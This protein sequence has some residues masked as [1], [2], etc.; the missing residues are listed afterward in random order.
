MGREMIFEVRKDGKPIWPDPNNIDDALFVC[1]RDDSTSYLANYVMNSMPE[2]S[3]DDTE[4]VVLLEQKDE[5]YF[6]IRER[7][8]EFYEKDLAEIQKA[9]DTLDD[10]REARRH[11]NYVDFF[12]FSESMEA[13]QE[14]IDDNNWSRAGHLI[15][16]LDKCMDRMNYLIESDVVDGCINQIENKKHYRVA[17]VWSE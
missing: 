8:E 2:D 13:T 10:L 12:K 17:I 15:E 9:K 4:P 6:Q 14:W 3:N 16:C 5:R 7:L 1:G 11:A